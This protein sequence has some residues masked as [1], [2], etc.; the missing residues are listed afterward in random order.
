A[1]AK[2]QSELGIS[3]EEFRQ[4]GK[5]SFPEDLYR[6]LL[7]EIRNHRS[8][9]ELIVSGFISGYPRIFKISGDVVW[10]C[11]DFAVI[12]SG[13]FNGESALRWREQSSTQNLE[14][15]IY[16]VWEAKRLSENVPGVGKKTILLIMRPNQ[17]TD[18]LTE[19][20]ER[21]L[22]DLLQ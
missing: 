8:G 7:W 5:S 12:G 4:T 22:N 19:A 15:T 17:P 18:F 13:T 11:N 16:N 20:G 10:P 14:T 21:M 2:L 3:Y 1:E 6:D 9:A